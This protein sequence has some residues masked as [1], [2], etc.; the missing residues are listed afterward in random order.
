MRSRT[1]IW[2]KNW[3]DA[4]AVDRPGLSAA[5]RETVLS[6]L[7]FRAVEDFLG[8]IAESVTPSERLR[9]LNGPVGG[10]SL[11]GNRL[12]R[13]RGAG[14]EAARHG[15]GD[16]RPEGHGKNHIQGPARDQPT[17]CGANSASPTA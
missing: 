2:S 8:R 5:L 1:L 3:A 17:T 4:L 13:Q 6:D 9:Q 15:D 11:R 16:V 12:G 10:H 7:E 14:R